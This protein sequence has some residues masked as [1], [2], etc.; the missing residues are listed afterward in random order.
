DRRRP[1]AAQPRHDNRCCSSTGARGGRAADLAL[2]RVVEKRCK[3]RCACRTRAA[4][5]GRVAGPHPAWEGGVA[6]QQP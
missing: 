3:P 1:V 4:G 2:G 6:D 5:A